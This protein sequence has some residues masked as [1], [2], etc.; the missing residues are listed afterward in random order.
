LE[1][2]IGEEEPSVVRQDRVD[3]QM[4]NKTTSF[5]DKPPLPNE[6]GGGHQQGQLFRG[7]GFSTRGSAA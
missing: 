1:V 3:L 6:G 7:E 2:V 5:I 4:R